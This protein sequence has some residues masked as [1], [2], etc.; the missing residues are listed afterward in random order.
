LRREVESMLAAHEKAKEAE[1]FLN[2]P[3]LQVAAQAIA[4]DHA[5]SLAPRKLGR[6]QILSLLGRGGMGEVYLAE[7]PRLGRKLALKLLPQEFTLD[8]ERVQRFKQEAR[9]ASGLNHPNIITIFEIDQ[10]QTEAGGVHFIAAEFIDGQTLRQCLA[11]GAM[12]LS[13]ALDVAVQVASALAAAH[14]AGIVHRDVK[15]EN[16]MLRRDGYVKVLDFGLA[17]LTEVG[18]GERTPSPTPNSPL[19]TP[20]LHSDPGVMMGTPRYM[21]P[22]QIRGRQV[23]ARADIFSLG[24]VLY[25]MVAG[26]VP[27]DGDAAG[28]VVA[29]IL[30]HEPA[31][32]GHY[33]PDAPGALGWIVDKA[34]A[35]DRER[36]YQSA[37]DLLVEL[38]GLKLELDLADKLKQ[39]GQTA[40]SIETGE[41]Q[42]MVADA[43]NT[44]LLSHPAPATHAHTKLEPVGGA[45][46]L[47]SKFYIIRGADEEFRAAI[48][49]QDSIV[50]I[51]GARQVGKTS[52]LA[53]GLQQ[54]RA[55]GAKVVLTDL[56]KLN[57]SDL[58][59][60]EAFYLAL[61][62]LIA[63]QLGLDVPPDAVW[64]ARRGPS[65]NFERYIRREALGKI[66]TPLVWGLDEVDRLFTCSFGSEVFGLFRSWHN[67]RSLDPA[68]PWQRLTMAIAYATEAHLFITDMNQSPFNVGTRLTLEDFTCQQVADLNERYG[69]PLKDEAEVARYYSLVSGHP[70]LARCG[71]QEMVVRRR[72]L[73]ELEA[74]ADQE[75]GPF[76]DHLRRVIA[77]LEQDPALCEVARGILQGQP[78]PTQE[79]FY[80]LRSAGL[81]A[82]DSARYVRPRC[83]LYA[84]YLEKRLL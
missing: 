13:E 40:T 22:E 9:A 11:G 42:S 65:I 26:R 25:E 57:A 72:D 4:D 79:S 67:E 68:G 82:G 12:K 14:A 19:P 29:A 71:L 56:Q 48:A 45:M 15:P 24:V 59:S 70:Y 46:P 83:Q 21:S 73:A 31:P 17:K 16:I 2:Q 52:L 60:A 49:R 1:D 36:R 53:R 8:R 35:K 3:A 63:D 28:E 33:A 6:Y 47:N 78:C 41:R 75:D 80:R 38:K 7:D 30:I 69:S 55:A 54:A 64:N 51:K 5:H 23:D 43:I 10:V 81:F 37:K 39:T 66:S 18:S 50:L 34:L 32:L 76:G 77:S 58:A 20:S 74:I 27:F 62:D 44:L 61:A 84:T